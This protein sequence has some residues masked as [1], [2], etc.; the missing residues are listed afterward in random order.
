MPAYAVKRLNICNFVQNCRGNVAGETED[1]AR[2]DIKS[3]THSGGKKTV[4]AGHK[5]S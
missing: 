2:N 1:Q 3:Y 5:K 4:R